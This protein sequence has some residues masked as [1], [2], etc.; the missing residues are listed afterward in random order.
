[1][2]PRPQFSRPQRHLPTA[3][4]IA[5]P[6]AAPRP[7]A[8]REAPLLTRDGLSWDGF[9]PDPYVD[10]SRT[11]TAEGGILIFYK[12][13][14]RRLRHTLW[15]IF[16]W[17]V[18]TGLEAWFLF[19][20]SP[21]HSIALTVAC[22][23]AIALVNLFI[24]LKPFEVYCSIEIRPECMIIDGRDIFWLRF[25]DTGFPAFRA[26]EEGNQILSGI[27]GTRFID[28]LCIP[29]FDELDCAPKVFAA[30]LKDAMQQLWTKPY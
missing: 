5:R 4:R 3:R 18:S 1:M 24:V 17:T 8:R 22:G 16:A 27:Y 6:V 20:H 30:H 12:D 13:Y 29:R 26:D 11:L 2:R 9:V 21:L 14:D 23:I 15:R 19:R 7:V 25:M 10:Y 28:Y